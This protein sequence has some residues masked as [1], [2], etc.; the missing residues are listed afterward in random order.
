MFG[1]SHLGKTLI[2]HNILKQECF[3][4]DHKNNVLLIGI[5]TKNKVQVICKAISLHFMIIYNLNTF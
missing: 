2:F 5:K 3:Y 1:T 4:T